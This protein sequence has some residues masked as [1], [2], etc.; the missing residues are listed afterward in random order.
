LTTGLAHSIQVRLDVHALASGMPLDVAVLAEALAATFARRRTVV[1]R[2][3]PVALTREFAD[4]PGR[5]AQWAGF[6]RR[7]LGTSPPELTVV[8]DA[9]AGFA[10]SVLLAVARGERFVGTWRPGGPWR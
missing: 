2:D 6:T 9:I 1:P 7:L 10:G 4:V 5:S 3:L 8:I